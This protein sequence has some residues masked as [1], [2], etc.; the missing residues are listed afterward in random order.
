M[1]GMSGSGQTRSVKYSRARIVAVGREKP[2]A[3]SCEGYAI[4]KTGLDR[5]FA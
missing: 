4:M 2:D 1:V 5:P 3:A